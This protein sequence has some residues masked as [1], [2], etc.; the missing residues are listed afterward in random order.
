MHNAFSG[1]SGVN[2]ESSKKTTTE[3]VVTSPVKGTPPSKKQ[4]QPTNSC[5]GHYICSDETGEQ[6][7]MSGYKGVD[8]RNRDFVGRNDPQC[9]TGSPCENGCTCWNTTCCC[10]NGFAGIVCQIKIVECLSQPCLHGGTCNEEFGYYRC[11]CLPG[12][13]CIYC[14]CL[15]E[16]TR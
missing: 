3:A 2:C 8:C 5:D 16:E 12:R 1:F 6:V 11:E 9:P 13:I 10:V 15:S 14:L 7:C 4:C